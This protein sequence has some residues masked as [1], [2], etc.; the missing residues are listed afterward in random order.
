MLKILKIFNPFNILK[1]FK[2][3]KKI[4]GIVVG[5]LILAL[6]GFAVGERFI[7]EAYAISTTLRVLSGDEVWV[8]EQGADWEE[9]EK[10]EMILKVGDG[11]K[12]GKDSYALI[13]YFD[14]SSMTLDPNSE[15]IIEEMSSEDGVVTLGIAQTLGR[16]WNRAEKFADPASQY[17][18]DT[19]SGVAVVRGSLIDIKVEEVDEVEI[20]TVVGAYEGMVEVTAAGVTMIVDAGMQTT[21]VKGEAPEPPEAI[22]LPPN[23]LEFYAKGPVWMLVVDPAGR[24]AGAVSPGVVVNQIPGTILSSAFAE[25]QF[26]VIPEPLDGKYTIAFHGR[27]EWRSEKEKARLEL[28]IE[29]AE[30][31]IEQLESKMEEAETEL[32]KAIEA[33]DLIGIAKW[34]AVKEMAK[35][36][37][38]KTQTEL[39]EAQAELEKLRLVPEGTFSLRVKGIGDGEEI[40]ER[41]KEDVDIE[42]G[43]MLQTT[44][45]VTVKDGAPV[46]GKLG[47]FEE[48]DEMPG[49]WSIKKDAKK[50]VGPVIEP[51]ADFTL[52]VTEEGNTIR[53]LNL[54]TGDIDSYEWDFGDGKTSD[55]LNPTHEYKEAGEAVGTGDG[56]TTVFYLDHPPVVPNSEVIYLDG[57]IT[58]AYSIDNNTGK[59]DFNTP[60]ATGVSITADYKK[61]G[62]TVNISLTVTGPGG[63]DTKTTKVF[64]IVLEAS[65]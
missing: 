42:K 26:V 14:G 37:M 1:I 60:P 33:K 49:K 59:I 30:L 50:K 3:S 41:S 61:S 9:V 36:E 57:V 4:M 20:I 15:V 23:R 25:A 46:S 62:F 40:F 34:T 44:L 47:K 29:T 35:R 48:I 13:T 12:T 53:F 10:E 8:S 11:V 52:E 31:K 5:V 19:P 7:G 43:Q 51:E 54:S 38:E 6:V 45:T 22:P 2:M 18:V 16:T 65:S 17:T 39:E 64:I 56:S 32:D 21:V 27:S 58:S 55:E 24:S 28:K 63:E